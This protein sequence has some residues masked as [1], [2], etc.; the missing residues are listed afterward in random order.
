MKISI[1]HNK[2]NSAF[3]TQILFTLY[4]ELTIHKHGTSMS[5]SMHKSSA[6]IASS[7]LQKV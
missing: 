3:L 1:S 5:I 7:V 2:D 6:M 4:L